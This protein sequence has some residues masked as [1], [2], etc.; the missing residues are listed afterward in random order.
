MKRIA[1][2]VAVL[3]M[4][5]ALGHAAPRSYQEA[6]IDDFR[7]QIPWDGKGP[8]KGSARYNT[9][10]A[11]GRELANERDPIRP[12]LNAAGRA[13]LNTVV[14]QVWEGV[15]GTK[16]DLPTPTPGAPTPTTTSTP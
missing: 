11:A 5:I 2:V 10:S 9:R 12:L 8:V 4:G 13:C 1:I 6:Y 15:H 14:K 3:L 16:L 7:I